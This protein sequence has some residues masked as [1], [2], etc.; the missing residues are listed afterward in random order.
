[1]ILV[2]QKVME[3]LKRLMEEESERQ[4]EEGGLVSGMGMEFVGVKRG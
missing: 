4:V 2:R 3:G 1:M